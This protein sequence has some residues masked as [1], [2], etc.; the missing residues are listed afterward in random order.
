VEY[1]VPYGKGNRLGQADDTCLIVPVGLPVRVVPQQSFSVSLIPFAGKM[2]RLRNL[3]RISVG[4]GFDYQFT[5]CHDAF[6][7]IFIDDAEK[8]PGLK[9][10]AFLSFSSKVL[11]ILLVEVCMG[12]NREYK[13]S[14]FSLLFGEE[15]T[16]RELY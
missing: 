15:N 6:L 11:Y 16:L 4:K 9:A 2:D 1:V 12:A 7:L 8:G 10:A 3:S 5:V 14:V 13:S